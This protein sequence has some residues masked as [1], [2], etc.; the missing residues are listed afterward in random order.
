MYI[1]NKSRFPTIP[2]ETVLMSWFYFALL[3]AISESLKDLCSKHGL[4]T[5]S[6]Q[7]AAFVAS[8]IPIPLLLTT[9]L[10]SDSFPSLGPQ[11]L[12]ALV[13]GGSLNILALFQF[14]RALQSS[15]MSLA[16]PFVSF[17]PIFLLITSPLLVN[18]V[19]NSQDV[20]GIF[21][22]VAGGICAS[23]SN[24]QSRLA[25]TNCS[26]IFSTWTKTYVIRRSDLQHHF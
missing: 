10:I 20:V 8:A 7:L 11:Y 18:E 4:R 25:H 15:E 12:P 17:T 23:D 9:L 22:I 2:Q 21:F 14:M 24:H 13:I 5:V 3:A 6:P 16:L 19:P 26:N 1:P